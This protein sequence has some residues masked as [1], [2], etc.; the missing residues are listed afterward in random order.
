MY[1]YY[2]REITKVV[3]GDTIDIIIDLGF[4]VFISSRI[5]LANIDSPESRTS[6]KFEKALG[7]E[8]K[9]YLEDHLKGAKD[10]II[11]TEKIDNTEKYGRILGWVYINGDSVSINDHMIN[12]GYAWKYMGDKKI[13]NFDELSTKRKVNIK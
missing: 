2:V 9:R 4:D 13:K 5:R 10:I 12:N 7:L 8:A 3:D 1:E 6:D 11:K